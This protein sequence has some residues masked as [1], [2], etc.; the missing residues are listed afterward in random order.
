MQMLG[1]GRKLPVILQTEATECGLCSLAMVANYHGFITDL[2][3]LRLRFS[4]SRKGATL[5]SLMRISKALKLDSRPLKLDMHNLPELQL[6]CIIHWGMDHFVVLKSVSKRRAIIHDP[7]V[8]IRSFSLEE[9]SN[10]FTG[11]A[12][13]LLPANDFQPSIARL[14]FSLTSL[15]GRVSGIKRGLLQI[16]LLAVVLELFAIS[17]PFYMQW[18]LD[19]ALVSADKELLLTLALG[20]ALLVIIHTAVNAT[21]NWFVVMLSK[22]LNFQWLGNVLAHLLK[23]PL[24]YF[25]KRST[26]S[27]IANFNSVTVIQQKLTTQFIQ[28]VVDGVM[29][30]GTLWMMALYSV[31]FTLIAIAVI[32]IYAGFRWSA[33][34]KLR[35]ASA[36][37]IV[38]ANRQSTHLLETVA[39]V[40]SIKLFDKNDQ[41]RAGWLNI[42][43]EQFNA[44]LRVQ[45]IRVRYESLQLLLFGLERILLIWL[46]AH[47]VLAHSFTVGMLFAFIAYKEQFMTRFASLIDKVVDFRL[48][49]LHGE[50]VADIVM[51]AS[52]PE[53]KWDLDEIDLSKINM[54]IEFRKVSF[55]YSPTENYIFENLSF[56]IG[57]G[58][59]V[60]FVGPS[61][62]GKTTLIKVLLG[63]LTP[64]SGDIFLGGVPILRIGL[65]NYR[66]LMGT[67]MQ[68]D[69]MFTGS[70]ADNICFFDP[71]PD[72]NRIAQCAQQAAIHEEIMDMP[73]AYYTIT[74]ENGVGVSGGQKQRIILARALYRLPRILI[75]DEA[76]SHLDVNN[77]K[78]VNATVANLGLTRILVA[79]RPETIA[80]A[81]RI[82]ELRKQ[83]SHG[84]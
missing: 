39:G 60:A 70:I 57:A 23:L 63:L 81:D 73:M 26:G 48:L 71:Q 6:P 52:E 24:E 61:G 78:I 21:R 64:T 55:R 36:E 44:D 7:S 59:C 15:M 20:F 30:L 67:V 58:E 14:E 75:L 12:L 25:E 49:H 51:S 13:E 3:T 56:K 42:L 27:I 65:S 72:M 80:M 47:A 53:N 4:I 79:H 45:S 84:S 9:F 17:L 82:I 31:P 83:N 29:V 69:R 38:H 68:D 2:S 33:Y 77:E 74:G 11:I 43:A 54:E 18:V 10:Y 1:L 16:F 62:S 37:E 35:V 32:T 50:R 66:R 46:G 76:T 40:Q 34:H 41:R 8:G 19:H 22:H 28:A 5:E